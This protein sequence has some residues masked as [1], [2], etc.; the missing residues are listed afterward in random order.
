MS[1]K[2][3]DTEMTS[4]LTTHTAKLWPFQGAP[5]WSVTWLP[6]RVLTHNQALTAMTI[7]EAVTTGLTAGNVDYWAGDAAGDWQ[8]NVDQWAAELG[9]TGPI[10]IAEASK[11]RAVLE[12]AAALDHN[13]AG[14]RCPSWCIED[15]DE[16]IVPAK[17]ELGYMNTHKSVGIVVSPG[18]LGDAEVRAIC[19]TGSET[20]LIELSANYGGERIELSIKDART[21][22]AIL[23][24]F[25]P[26]RGELPVTGAILSTID[27]VTVDHA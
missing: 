16:P 17:P 12:A 9:I 21:L 13:R 24:M 10:A 14:D 20:P 19:P 15:H 2:I 26:H 18:H 6:G 25:L 7:A 3:T 1:V 23:P 8:L 5:A 4:D 11:P 27:M 22:T